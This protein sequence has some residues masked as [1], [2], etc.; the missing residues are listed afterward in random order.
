MR[1]AG[2]D[3]EIVAGFSDI[4]GHAGA[5]VRHASGLIEGAAD[6]RGDGVVAAF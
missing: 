2:H 1:E 3:V 6:P 5:L 4:M